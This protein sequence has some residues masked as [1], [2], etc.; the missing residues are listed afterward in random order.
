MTKHKVKEYTTITM[1]L[2][3]KDNGNKISNTGMATRHGQ[4]IA[5]IRDITRWV[6]NVGKVNTSGKI[7]AHMK[8]IG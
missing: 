8:E 1:V 5:G 4:I 2:S 6:R 7:K 3:I